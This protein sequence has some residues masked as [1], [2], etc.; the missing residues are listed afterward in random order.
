ML[1]KH[2]GD[3]LYTAASISLCHFDNTPKG[4]IAVGWL[5]Y[6]LG[7][8]K[9]HLT[10]AA[11]VPAGAP[12]RLKSLPGFLSQVGWTKRRKG[13]GGRRSAL[14]RSFTRRFPN[15]IPW[16][17]IP[18]FSQTLKAQPKSWR[19][20]KYSARGKNSLVQSSPQAILPKVVLVFHA[21]ARSV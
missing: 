7:S 5:G 11:W 15:Y 12:I 6:K 9:T 19:N 18:T 3:T 20:W 14:S 17:T 21:C 8:E 4:D 16:S 10:L 13:G 1:L 2:A